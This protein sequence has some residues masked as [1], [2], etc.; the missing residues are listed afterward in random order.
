MSRLQ[1]VSKVVSGVLQEVP[2]LLVQA[3]YG[4]LVEIAVN[5]FYRID[6]KLK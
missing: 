4:N 1:L 6:T 2:E 3:E 5:R